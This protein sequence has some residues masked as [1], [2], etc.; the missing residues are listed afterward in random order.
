MKKNQVYTD[1]GLEKYIK[2]LGLLC[3]DGGYG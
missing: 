3:L 1:S 2:W